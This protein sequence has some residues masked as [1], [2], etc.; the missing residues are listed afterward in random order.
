MSAFYW[1]LFW[2]G[3]LFGALTIYKWF[4]RSKTT[5]PPGEKPD[6]GTGPNLKRSTRRVIWDAAQKGSRVVIRDGVFYIDRR[7][8]L[9]R[10]F[11]SVL[12]LLGIA[13]FGR[14]AMAASDHLLQVDGKSRI[15]EGSG[16][17]HFD[18]PASHSDSPHY[19]QS[20]HSDSPAND[21]HPHIDDSLMHQDNPHSDDPGSHTD[22]PD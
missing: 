9:V 6:G 18:V 14:S 13:A 1:V 3:V 19:D 16:G 12:A 8:A 2:S 17:G 15:A 11:G 22:N 21:N 7:T 20:P 5:R 10:G 4:Q